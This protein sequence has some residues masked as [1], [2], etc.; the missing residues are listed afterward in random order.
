MSL[1]P[2]AS[3]PCFCDCA[4]HREGSAGPEQ[5]ALGLCES[6]G[7][8]FACNEN[9][10]NAVRVR[11]RLDHQCT[12]GS[13]KMLSGWEGMWSLGSG[14]GGAVQVYVSQQLAQA[15]FSLSPRLLQSPVVWLGCSFA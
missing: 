14:R 8:A 12:C 13:V 2:R 10:E 4:C 6:I 7:L 9:E 11:G 1:P 5:L 15:C 3:A